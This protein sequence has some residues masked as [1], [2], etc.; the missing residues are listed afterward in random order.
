MILTD[1]GAQNAPQT[2]PEPKAKSR[3][4]TAD[5]PEAEGEP[6]ET[7]QVKVR[8]SAHPNKCIISDSHD[9]NG[10][11]TEAHTLRRHLGP[12]EVQKRKP[13]TIRIRLNHCKQE[14]AY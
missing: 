10:G 3:G 11:N 7:A 13:A 6:G 4:T 1:K 14:N 12:Q 2:M 8:H 5:K 9:K